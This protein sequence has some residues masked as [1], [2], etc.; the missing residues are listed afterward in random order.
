MAT[1]PPPRKGFRVRV[2]TGMR[3]S[4][5]NWSIPGLLNRSSP[6]TPISPEPDFI[7]IARSTSPKLKRDGSTT[8]LTQVDT[9]HPP[10][11]R[12]LSPVSSSHMS[13]KPSPTF[14]WAR[15]R[16]IV[17]STYTWSNPSS[18]FNQSEASLTTPSEDPFADLGPAA[19][20]PHLY[21]SPQPGVISSSIVAD[22]FDPRSPRDDSTIAPAELVAVPLPTIYEVMLTPSVRQVSSGTS[23]DDRSA[24]EYFASRDI[25]RD[26]NERHPLIPRQRH[27][28]TCPYASCGWIEQTYP[29]GGKYFV[30]PRIQATTDIDLRNL[31]KLEAVMSVV[32]TAGS[33]PE[34]CEMW[35][36]EDP[37]VKR[38]RRRQQ[39][40]GWPVIS[41]IDH[42]IRRV[43]SE[44][45]GVDGIIFSGEDDRLDDEYRYWSFVESH[46]AHISLPRSARKEA[47]E[48]LHWSYTDLLLA[49]PQLV[50]P[51]FSQ[52]ECHKSLVHLNDPSLRSTTTH[53]QMIARILL[54]VVHW[55]QM[56]FRPHK[57]LPRD[58]PIM[59]HPKRCVPKASMMRCD[60]LL[61]ADRVVAAAELHQYIIRFNEDAEDSFSPWS[62]AFKK[63]CT[64]RC[65]AKG[66]EAVAEGNYE[67]A[68]K[69]YSAGISLDSLCESLL[70][71][72]S[73][74][75]LERKFYAEALQ[76]A[77]KATELNSSSYLGYKLKHAAL[78][79]SQRYDEA[80][81]AF[82]TMLLKL[83]DAPDV[84]TRKLRHKY[85]SPSAVKDI[86][87]RAI[88]AQLENAP[89]R[90]LNTST[91]RLCDREAQIN[92]FKES[93]EYKEILSSS[94]TH[95][96]LQTEPIE[97]AVVKYFS[98][99]MLSHKWESQ[100]P[101]LHDI[102]DK[103]V[104]DLDPVG[105]VVKLQTFCKITHDAGYRWAWSDTC[106]ID[107]T[108]NVELQR[109]VNTMFVWY[110][111]SALTIIYLS[112]V[113]PS[114]R[115]GALANSVW[116]TRGWTVQEFL[117]PNIILFYQ[118]DWTLY[119]NDTSPNHKMSDA[120][121]AELKDSTGIDAQSLIAFRPGMTDARK[122]LQWSSTRA[123][124][125][126]EDI[127]YS[128]FG[129][130]GIYLP[131]IYGESKQNALGRLL[132]EIIAQSGDITALD[133]VGKSSQ[134]NSCLPAEIASYKPPPYTSPPLSEDQIRTSVSSLRENSAVI[135]LA[136]PLYTQLANLNPPRFA[137]SRLR[138][139][140]IAFPVTALR[141]R[142]G[143]DR[144]KCFIHDAKVDGLH[145]LVITTKDKLIQFWPARPTP[146][147]FLLV[148]PW[149]R[150]DLG[151][152]DFADETESDSD[153]PPSDEWLGG[154]H[155]EDQLIDSESHSRELRLVVH[156][157]QPFGALLLAQQR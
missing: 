39:M 27:L 12:N 10:S 97:E 92:A 81:E 132:Q 140:C 46:P 2:G 18:E 57:P 82:K 96:P 94:M 126:Q 62:T 127:A 102:Q 86:I 24:D 101:R 16:E 17:G 103:I 148:R 77:D 145:N 67:A 5:S 3:R 37:T 157:G 143:Q 98:W 80:I 129:I 59:Q 15:E 72:R 125:L 117:A 8:S 76:D 38:D 54:R 25:P 19:P 30:N 123:T 120:I 21:P 66:D 35:A 90:L 152:P 100:E 87:L 139:P 32:E 135:E 131:V 91:G 155:R 42:R 65:L 36:R 85:V 28:D 34:G 153:P 48:A 128:L 56:H 108:N 141:R 63:N 69:L 95:L 134:F 119:L 64:A 61:C 84:Q 138:L 156:L 50:S 70:A 71:H 47:I 60:A 22:D 116:N 73:K 51:P 115:P 6:A 137:N 110:R 114:A 121:M 43:S 7:P 23:S 107:Q 130:F 55:R 149:N 14:R 53:T 9:T 58:V 118:K 150:H 113:P 142:R 133:W 33:A 29:L 40:A 68:I 105:T 146:R 13:P 78:H 124:T 89:L 111:N 20:S 4:S 106:C 75:N 109:S 99:V 74:A 122:K 88:H 52:D 1:A 154:Y 26:T 49:H 45:P 147:T 112:D 44:V 144:E 93:T 31:T 83:D 104:Y 151:L 41:W 11:Q 79:G 136:L